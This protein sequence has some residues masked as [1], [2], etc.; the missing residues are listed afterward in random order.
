MGQVRDHCALL[1]K[2]FEEAGKQPLK[3]RLSPRQQKVDVVLLR[4]GRA[5]YRVIRQGVAI[6]NDDL[7]EMGRQNPG[8]QQSCDAAAYHDRPLRECTGVTCHGNSS[9]NSAEACRN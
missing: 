5:G 9:M 1:L 4:H 8:S 6:D 2:L 3:D 7:A